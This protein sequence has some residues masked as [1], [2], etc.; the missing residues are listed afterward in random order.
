MHL[1]G[2]VYGEQLMAQL[3]RSIP[4]RQWLFRFGR[5]PLHVVAPIRMWEVSTTF[6]LPFPFRTQT[7]KIAAYEIFFRRIDTV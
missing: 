4:D 2:D 5:V 6:P 1:S 3:L 7:I